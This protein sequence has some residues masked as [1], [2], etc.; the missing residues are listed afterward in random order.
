MARAGGEIRGSA[1]DRRARRVKLILVY[2]DGVKVACVHCG[3]LVD[4]D[5][6]EVDK[7]IPGS[8][9]V[10]GTSGQTSSLAAYI[11]T[12]FAATKPR[13]PRFASYRAC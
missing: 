2:G 4:N 11:A 10:A 1:A 3:A 5:G 12:G 7:I 9:K 6:M 8:A 13:W